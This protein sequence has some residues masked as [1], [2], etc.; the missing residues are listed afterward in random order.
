MSVSLNGFI[1]KFNNKNYI[2]SIH[3]NLPIKSVY[4][5]NSLLNI[6]INS[7]WSEILILD[8]PSIL[9]DLKIH[10]TNPDIEHIH[11]VKKSAPK[12]TFNIEIK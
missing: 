11:V 9:N 12:K 4:Y 1:F 6:K 3:H 10:K 2:I 8:L 5:D 7:N